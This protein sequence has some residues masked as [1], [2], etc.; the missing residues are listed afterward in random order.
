MVLV[1]PAVGVA[2]GP[3]GLVARGPPAVEVGTT[4]LQLEKRKNVVYV[5]IPC[6]SSTFVVGDAVQL[7]R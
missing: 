2:K 1:T 7:C 6:A 4:S 3:P 5:N